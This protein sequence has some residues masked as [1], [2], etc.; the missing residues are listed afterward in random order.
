MHMWR[1][2]QSRTSNI[3]DHLSAFYFLSGNNCHLTH[4]SEKCFVSITVIDHHVIAVTGFAIIRT[5][6]I[7]TLEKRHV[8][9]HH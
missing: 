6:P 5:F 4:V 2:A 1:C 3:T 9:Y 8:A 7:L